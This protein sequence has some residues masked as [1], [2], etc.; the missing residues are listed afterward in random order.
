MVPSCSGAGGLIQG[1]GEVEEGSPQGNPSPVTELSIPGKFGFSPGREALNLCEVPVGPYGALGGPG[2]G[3][4]VLGCLQ[5]WMWA[6][7]GRAELG[8]ASDPLFHHCLF[9]RGKVFN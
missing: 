1:L 9:D 5:Q 2:W 6:G 4:E 7:G 8:V 3:Q